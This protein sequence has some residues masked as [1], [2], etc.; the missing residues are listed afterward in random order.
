MFSDLA[1]RMSQLVSP[2]RFCTPSVYLKEQFTLVYQTNETTIHSLHRVPHL[3]EKTSFKYTKHQD[4]TKIRVRK[5]YT[6]CIATVFTKLHIQKNFTEQ[7][8]TV[9]AQ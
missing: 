3:L 8:L 2:I 5:N 1:S 9:I 4:G 6:T 7:I